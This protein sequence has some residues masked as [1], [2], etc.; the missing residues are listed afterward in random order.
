MGVK[1]KVRPTPKRAALK[2]FAASIRTVNYVGLSRN[3]RI[4]RRLSVGRPSETG[5][6]VTP[7]TLGTVPRR[8]SGPIQFAL[9]LA[10]FWRL[11]REDLAGLLGFG[12][13]DA[14]H[15]TAMLTGRE[16]LHGRDVRDR[17]A[18]LF[19]I[20]EA[21]HSLFRDLEVENEWLREPHDLLEGKFPMS[22]MV[23]GSM[24]DLLLVREY[25]DEVAGS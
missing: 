25:V 12:D 15:A 21:L 19:R 4:G 7:R 10:D 1:K 8:P 6:Q 17:I 14:D 22:L 11:S 18:H 3:P 24:E 20:K 5:R 16:E 13:G 2:K 23:G 9:K